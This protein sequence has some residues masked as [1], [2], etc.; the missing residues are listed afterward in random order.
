MMFENVSIPLSLHFLYSKRSF[1]KL[2]SSLLEMPLA[3]RRNTTLFLDNCKWEEIIES[4]EIKVY[5]KHFSRLAL[6][7]EYRDGRIPNTYN[8]FY[9]K[10]TSNIRRRPCRYP[11]ESLSIDKNLNVYRCPFCRSRVLFKAREINEIQNDKRYLMFLAS[12]LT[13]DLSVFQECRKCPYW[14]DGWLADE[15]K[16]YTSG[17]MRFRLLFQGH[18]CIISREGDK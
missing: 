11:F 2:L 3:L 10:G 4:N 9:H 5:L 16:F 18:G 6:T 1:P 7:Y 12:H 17:D 14:L 8:G 15:T 13:G